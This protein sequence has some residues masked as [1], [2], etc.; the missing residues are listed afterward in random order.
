MGK[1]DLLIFVEDAGAANY[2]A[3]LPAA[4]ARRGVR[5]RLFASGV[6]RDYL[7]Q[8]EIDFEVGPRPQDA[9]QLLASVDPSL[10]LVGTAENTDTLGLALIEKARHAGIQS[11]AAVDARSNA[12]RRF[13]GGGHHALAY[14]PDWLL[15]PDEWTKDAF[16]ALGYS[17]SR[18]LICGHPHYDQVHDTFTRLASVDR[19][20]LRQKLL[21]GANGQRVLIF[22][23]EVSNGLEPQ[24]YQRSPEYTLSGRGTSTGRT[25]IVIEELLDALRPMKPRPYLVLRLH[26]KNKREDFVSYLDEFD[27]MSKDEPPLELVYVADLVVGMTSIILLEAALMSCPTLSVVPRLSETEWLPSA[28]LG[29]ARATTR[30][31]LKSSLEI[32]LSAP[33]PL[34]PNFNVGVVRGALKRTVETIEKLLPQSY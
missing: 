2:V 16:V 22:A 8:H 27:C 28:D 1:T 18:A 29:I 12:D 33:A 34:Q 25:E 9:E 30:E 31:Q 15:L 20:A 11:V 23:A 14:A 5:C 17:A 26:P 3:Q 4:L 6:A 10:L 19:S 21:P 24:Q 7:G 13:R 32:L